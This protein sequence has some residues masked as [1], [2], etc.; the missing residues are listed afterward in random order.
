LGRNRDRKFVG[1]IYFGRA[2]RNCILTNDGSR[3]GLWGIGE[4]PDVS[5][6]MFQPN[7]LTIWY[8]PAKDYIGSRRRGACG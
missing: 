7:E 6:D 3:N 4:Y 1:N 5:E 8:I 2:L